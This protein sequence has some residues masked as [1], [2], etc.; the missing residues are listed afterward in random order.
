MKARSCK[1]LSDA[2]LS[3]AWVKEL[4][5][6]HNVPYEVGE[7]VYGLLQLDQG[8]FAFFVDS[9][10]P[11]SNGLLV[12]KENLGSLFRRPASGCF[13]IENAHAFNGAVEGTLVG[14]HAAES[15]VFEADLFSEEGDFSFGIIKI[16]LDASDFA[17]FCFG[18]APGNR[19][20]P[21]GCPG[22]PSFDGHFGRKKLEM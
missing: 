2:E 9:M 17:A 22:P 12:K 21:G 19:I 14:W 3:H 20:D 1:K 5:P 18:K 6:E 10:K 13:E 16:G 11:P 4:E 8:F 15:L 7:L